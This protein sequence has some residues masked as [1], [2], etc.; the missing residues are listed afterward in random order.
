MERTLKKLTN[1]L[2]KGEKEYII[3]FCRMSKSFSP[4]YITL[5]KHILKEKGIKTD[6]L[7][8]QLINK[9]FL[10][11]FSNKKITLFKKILISIMN[12]NLENS[13]SWVVLRD[14]LFIKTLEEKGLYDKCKNYIKRAKHNA[15]KLEEYLLLLNIIDCEI[16]LCF[17][18]NYIIDY[19]HYNDLKK[20]RKNVI[21][22]LDNLDSLLTIK[23][24]LQQYQV[25]VCGAP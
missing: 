6:I 23:T 19:I 1:K 18:D 25:D 10:K 21:A 13:K 24:E 8:N 16:K 20:E 3:N 22:I 17:Q 2:S 7:Q 4:D 12:Y 15:Y 11:Y 14:M 9:T 5:F